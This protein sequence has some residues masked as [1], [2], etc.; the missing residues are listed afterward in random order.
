MPDTR[1]RS[2]S[3]GQLGGRDDG[4]GDRVLIVDFGSQYTQ[5]IARRVREL[6]AYSEI[7]DYQRLTAGALTKFSPCCIILSGGPES[8]AADSFPTIPGSVFDCGKP[9]LGICYGMQAMASRLGGIVEPSAHREFG[10]ARLSVVAGNRLLDGTDSSFKVWM[11]HGD[12]VIEVPPGFS[13]IA[14]TTASP[15]AAMA[16]VSRG[17]YGLQFHPEVTHTS[18]GAE[19]LKRFIVDIAGCKPSWTTRAIIDREVERIRRQVGEE[20]VIL[21]LSGGVDSAVAAALIHRA[22]GLQLH[23]V[24]VDTGLLRQGEAGQVADTFADYAGIDLIQVKAQDVFF[25]SLRGVSDPEEKRKVIGNLFVA[26]FEEEARKLP[27]VKWLAQGTIYPD[28]IESSK[29]AHAPS[30]VIKSH[31]NVGGLPERMQLKLLEPLSALFKDEVR[32][33]GIELGLPQEIIGRHPFPGPGFAVRVIGEVRREHVE[34]LRVADHIFIEELKRAS[35]YDS[36]SQAFVVFLPVKSVSIMGDKRE[37][38]HVLVLRAVETSDFMTADRSHLPEEFLSH[39]ARRIVNE[40]AGVSR[41][42]YDV[43]SKPPATI[44]WE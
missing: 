32:K 18:G 26:L 41:V 25:K 9:V 43:T 39:V 44:E 38:S 15:I 31:H 13:V 36:V 14:T 33:L 3:A 29:Q 27:Q 1:E 11:S 12:R 37:Y 6:G 7:F 17:Y 22:I 40:V 23:C 10:D 20:H 8:T 34:L 24:F 30:R 4:V 2:D 16:D 42:C 21:G 28:V 19:I 5:L 35:L